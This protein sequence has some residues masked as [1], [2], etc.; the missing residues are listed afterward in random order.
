M[1][2]TAAPMPLRLLACAVLLCVAAGAA[3]ADQRGDALLR[4]FRAWLAREYGS[5]DA[6]NGEWGTRFKAWPEVEPLTLRQARARKQYPRWADYA[7]FMEKASGK[8][9]PR[10]AARSVRWAALMRGARRGTGIDE[11]ISRLLA[12]TRPVLDEIVMHDSAASRRGARLLGVEGRHERTKAAWAF[13][14]RDT[15]AQFTWLD[16]E[17]IE[18]GALEK[19]GRRI[20]ILP[21]SMAL[22]PA[23]AVAIKRFVRGGGGLVAD[24]AAGIMNQRCRPLGRGL[25]DDVFAVERKGEARA[26]NSRGVRILRD[27]PRFSLPRVT[28][29]GWTVVDANVR[30]T[31][32][33]ALAESA[34]AGAAAFV[35]HRYGA[36]RSVYL[37]ARVNSY[38]AA[39]KSGGNAVRTARRVLGALFAGLGVKPAIRVVSLDGKAN[40]HEVVAFED[41]DDLYVGA[42]YDLTEKSDRIRIELPAR[43]LLYDLRRRKALGL[44]DAIGALELKQR[45]G[46]LLFAAL[47]RQGGAPVVLPQAR[48]R[49]GETVR[50]R[51]RPP[52]GVGR[53]VYSVRILDPADR[54]RRE[55]GRIIVCD[56]AVGSGEFGA[57]AGDPPGVWRIVATDA[58]TGA[59]G[60]ADVTLGGAD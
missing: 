42:L 59:H 45:T 32:A 29:R 4:P 58:V 34:P 24:S 25:L 46:A 43:R 36:G 12:G 27:A 1:K 8:R 54:E 53:R 9:P 19:G 16:R 51:V 38:F 3:S 55:Y 5:L 48:V 49:A 17:Q 13:L 47:A 11:A 33:V 37:N 18:A 50:Y 52:R 30:P 26:P 22:S 20:L 28:L 57:A 35:T 14:V 40:N 7:A 41:G 60:R 23:E 2:K 21:D 56:R 15:G 6:L 31:T 10:R 39:R 44:G